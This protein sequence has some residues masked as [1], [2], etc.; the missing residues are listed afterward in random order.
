[1]VTY[2]IIP[3]FNCF[4]MAVKNWKTVLNSLQEWGEGQVWLLKNNRRDHFGD[5]TALCFD[6]QCQYPDCD[7]V[8]KFYK[9]LPLG[10]TG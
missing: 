1:M 3:L 10:K 8:V 5:G 2:Y 9:M 4:E 6:Y 7:N